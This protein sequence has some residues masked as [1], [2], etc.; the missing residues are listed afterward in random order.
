MARKKEDRHSRRADRENNYSQQNY[1]QDPNGQY[2]QQNGNGTYYDPNG[3]QYYQQNG[4]GTYYDPNGQQYYQQNGNGSYYDPNGQQYYQQNGNST[5]YDPN[6]Q[7]YYQQN[8]NGPYYQQGMSDQQYFRQAEDFGQGKASAKKTKGRKV[9]RRILFVLEILVLLILAGGLYIG[10]T[11]SKMD[12]V[13]IEE[14]A[15]VENVQEQLDEKVVEKLK[16]YWNIALFGVD[17][18]QSSSEN[19][20]S[21]TIIV[22][23]INRDTKEIR[24]ASVYRD[25]YLD[26]TNGEFR[27]ANDAYLQGGPERAINMLNRNLDLDI[28]NFVTVNM[29]VLAEVVNDIGGVEIDVRQ[30]EIEHLNNYQN[31]GSEITGLEKIPVTTPGLQTLNGLQAM[32][33]CRIRY[34]GLDYERTERQRK[35]LTQIF[36]KVQNMDILSLTG[37]ITDILPYIST[38]LTQTEILSLAKDVAS[39]KLGEN[40]GFPFDKLAADVDAGDCVVPVNL[41]QNVTQLHSFLFGDDENY[42]PSETVQSISNTIM[43]R[44]GIY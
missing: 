8:G 14:S 25:T 33:Y 41:A 9:R 1:R 22:A 3:Q 30:E 31:E 19:G 37:I 15:I 34:I 6:G 26:N 20:L 35:V 10:A 16:G 4:N 13:D 17:S 28:T 39:Y 38:N 21:D 18:R 23:S 2:Y 27:K 24:M 29:S 12:T 32:S 36:Q 40:T 43:E 5:Y 7:Q 42:I 11:L 44:T